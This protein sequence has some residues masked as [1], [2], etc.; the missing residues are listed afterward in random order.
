[1]SHKNKHTDVLKSDRQVAV[2]CRNATR[3][4]SSILKMAATLATST[5]EE[6]RSAISFL[7]SEG[8]KPT[9]IHRR[10]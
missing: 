3:Q 1:M 10:M 7:S 9:E 4:R 8:V 6:Q 5:K 2:R